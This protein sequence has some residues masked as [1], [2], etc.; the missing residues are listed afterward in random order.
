[1][2]ISKFLSFFE[3]FF[4]RGLLSCQDPTAAQPQNPAKSA[5]KRPKTPP[6]AAALAKILPQAA[7]NRPQAA[8]NSRRPAKN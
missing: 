5:G 8:K 7:K 3:V 4:S 1:V 2:K 6:P